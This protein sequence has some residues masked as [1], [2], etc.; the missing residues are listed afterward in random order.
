MNSCSWKEQRTVNWKRSYLKNGQMFRWDMTQ[1]ESDRIYSDACV[2]NF[3]DH[4]YEV[5]WCTAGIAAQLSSFVL[6]CYYGSDDVHHYYRQYLIYYCY[7][8]HQYDINFIIYITDYCHFNVDKDSKHF[9]TF[10]EHNVTFGHSIWGI[11]CL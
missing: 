8:Y 2:Y 11:L 3:H 4:Y 6:F 1:M 10:M 9:L 7:Q 5:L